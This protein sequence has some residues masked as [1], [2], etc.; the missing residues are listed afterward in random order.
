MSIYIYIYIERMKET[1]IH[2]YIH[3]HIS[4]ANIFAG[5]HSLFFLCFSHLCLICYPCLHVFFRCLHPCYVHPHYYSAMFVIFGGLYCIS[6]RLP[7]CINVSNQHYARP[8]E[9][10]NAKHGKTQKPKMKHFS[11]SEKKG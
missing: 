8:L 4:H 5:F 1:H 6:V 7:C 3:M 11:K 2:V 10:I 9:G